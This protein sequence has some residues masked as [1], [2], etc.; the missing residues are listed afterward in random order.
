MPTYIFHNTET[1]EYWEELMKISEMESFLEEYPAV[2]VVPQAPMIVTGVNVK[3]GRN[4]G[5]FNEVMSKVAEANPYSP[6]AEKYGSK[7]S[8]SVKRRELVDKHLKRKKK[9]KW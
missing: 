9:L 2:K 4:D 7:D 5:A 1:D 3:G 6:H 8:K